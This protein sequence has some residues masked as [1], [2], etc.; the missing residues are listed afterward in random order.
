M[1]PRQM[2][3][4]KHSQE[5]KRKQE[6]F[7][8]E[9]RRMKAE[10]AKME[11]IWRGYVEMIVEML[12]L[13][14]KEKEYQRAKQEFGRENMKSGLMMAFVRETEEEDGLKVV[15]GHKYYPHP[16][17]GYDPKSS[18][19]TETTID[20]KGWEKK[21]RANAKDCEGDLTRV[22]REMEELKKIQEELSA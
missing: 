18:T 7:E 16:D 20:R 12:R 9:Q 14:G 5:Q 8:R 1:N 2:R 13:T 22:K 19:M 3:E 10:H 17:L 15:V 11:S 6:Q 4:Y 21:Y